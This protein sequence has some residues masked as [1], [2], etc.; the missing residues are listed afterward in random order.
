MLEVVRAT[1]TYVAFAIVVV[2]SAAMYCNHVNRAVGEAGL[3]EAVE[4]HVAGLNTG[5]D[6]AI[7]G[8]AIGLVDSVR[9]RC[10]IGFSRRQARCILKAGSMTEVRACRR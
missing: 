5:P 6:G 10:E 3:C 9:D 2:G 7:P 8:H 4:R 1:R